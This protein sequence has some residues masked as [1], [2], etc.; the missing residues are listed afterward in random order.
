[1]V[2]IGVMIFG[3]LLV[4]L[5]TLL[6]VRK[7]HIMSYEVRDSARS[8]IDAL[9]RQLEI[10]LGLYIDLGLTKSLP[11]TRGWA[12]SPDFLMELVKHTLREKPTT[13][14]ECSSG[15]STLILARC[16]QINGGGKV[17]SLEHDP[18]YA[19]QTIAQ[20]ARHGLSEFAEV[21]VAPLEPMTASGESWKW[22]G[23]GILPESAP[24]DM[25]VIDGPPMATGPL[26]RY[27]AGPVL[28]PRLSP[29]AA[30]F[31]DD[32]ERDSEKS[33]LARWKVEFPQLSFS[34]AFSEKGCAILRSGAL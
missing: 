32:A 2:V 33:I 19:E 34:T 4:C 5:Y 28:F 30:V 13:V 23:H 20:L 1:M 24:I 11:G 27:P 3:V 8:D 10:L 15:T 7:I 26:A 31:L 16:M 21:F 29:K 12:A 18:I 22:Y 17:Y 25:L 9:Y 14:V 6:K